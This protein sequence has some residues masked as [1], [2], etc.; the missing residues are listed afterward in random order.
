ML[1]LIMGMPGTGKS[2]WA[3]DHLGAAGLAYDLDAIAGAFRLCA[4]H[5]DQS[6]EARALADDLLPCWL[7]AARQHTDDVYVIR[8][9][10]TLPELESIAP[11]RAVCCMTRH[12]RQGAG[13]A[14]RM[15]RRLADADAWLQ[16]HG[17]PV[18][19]LW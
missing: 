5:E 19:Y 3:R 16:D 6:P 2:T 14:V 4:A 17:I 9:A 18:T 1:T 8:T 10:P 12:T 13:D 7:R 15:A 11:D